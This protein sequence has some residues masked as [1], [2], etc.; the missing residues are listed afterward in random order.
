MTVEQFHLFANRLRDHGVQFIVEPHLRFKAR[1]DGCLAAE[2]CCLASCCVMSPYNFRSS[3][4]RVL[5][6]TLL[7]CTHPLS[8]SQVLAACVDTRWLFLV[9]TLGA[10]YL[11]VT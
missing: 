5:Q 11:G 4:L 6:L 3:P 1:S 7:G 9:W 8:Y 2:V 10:R